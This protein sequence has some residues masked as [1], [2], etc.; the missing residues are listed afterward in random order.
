VVGASELGPILIS[1]RRGEQRFVALGF[2]PRDSDLVLRVAWPLLVLNVI[3][4]FVEE[5]VHYVSSYPTG[6]VWQ[7]PGLGDIGAAWIQRSDAPAERLLVRSGTATHL[8]LHAGFHSLGVEGSTT[9]L[10][11]LAA[12]LADPEE[13]HIKPRRELPVLETRVA[14][15]AATG[16]GARQEPWAY[17][18][19]LVLVLSCVEWLTYHR[20]LTV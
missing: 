2:D 4:H 14:E 10:R 15:A 17:L 12:N 5:S 13:S 8:G 1:G 11:R 20:R 18:L 19:V 6:E 9:V 3:N 16:G 7:I